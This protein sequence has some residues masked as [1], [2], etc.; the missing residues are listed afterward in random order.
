MGASSMEE[1]A[2]NTY[3][4]AL[5]FFKGYDEAE[6]ERVKELLASELKVL[7]TFEE[8]EDGN[9]RVGMKAWIGVG[10]KRG[11]EEIAPM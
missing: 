9:V 4:F 3:E 1:L 2:A 11:D 6:L 8:L 10:W 7:R 5:L